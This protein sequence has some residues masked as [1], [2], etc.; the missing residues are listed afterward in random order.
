MLRF[1]SEDLQRYNVKELSTFIRGEKDEEEQPERHQANRG[2]DEYEPDESSQW[3]AFKRVIQKKLIS[4]MSP[5]ELFGIFDTEDRRV[6]DLQ[7]LHGGAREL[8]VTMTRPEARAVL[9]RM[10]LAVD[11]VDRKS[12]LPSLGIDHEKPE[13]QLRRRYADDDEEEDLPR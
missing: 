1:D 4:G 9:R 6:L 12:F 10:C 2:D 13:K 3:V 11:V 5:N 7:S 8:G